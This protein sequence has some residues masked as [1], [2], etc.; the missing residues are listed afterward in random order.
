MR[1][2]KFI[3]E[4]AN[5]SIGDTEKFSP[6]LASALVNK[7]EVAEYTTFK[8]KT[9]VPSKGAT[10]PKPE[11][12]EE[13]KDEAV[14]ETPESVEEPKAEIEEE[15]PKEKKGLFGRKK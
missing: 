15:Q 2:V 12:E 9:V 1:E 6:G 7:H 10:E 8:V 5:H 13:I 4:F 11:A 14:V 3:K